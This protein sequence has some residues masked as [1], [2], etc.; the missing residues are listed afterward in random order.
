MSFFNGAFRKYPYQDL[1]EYNLDWI[2]NRLKELDYDMT[3]FVESNVLKYHDPIDWDINT[4]Y[5]AN[6]VVRSGTKVYLSKKPVPVGV[7]IS[8]VNYWFEIGDTGANVN[9]INKRMRM[10]Q[11]APEIALLGDSSIRDITDDTMIT[12]YFNGANVSNYYR[13][14]DGN[15]GW[16]NLNVQIQRISDTPDIIIIQCG[17]NNIP[18]T[19]SADFGGIM[20]APDITDHTVSNNPQTIFEWMKYDINYLKNAF[21][22]AQIYTILRATHPTKPRIYWEY[23]SYFFKAIMREWAVPVIDAQELVNFSTFVTAQNTIF[24]QSDGIHYNQDMYARWLPKLSNII[25]SGSPTDSALTR[26]A[27]FFAPASVLDA[28]YAATSDYNYRALL[29]WVVRH[30]LQPG[31]GSNA[32]TFFGKVAAYDSNNLGHVGVSFL[33]FVD[34][35]AS[36]KIVYTSGA[37]LNSYTLTSSDSVANNGPIVGTRDVASNNT[38]AWYNFQ[39]GDYVV[40]YSA[41]GTLSLPAAVETILAVAQANVIMRIRRSYNDNDQTSYAVH[42][43]FVPSRNASLVKG[44]RRVSDNAESWYEYTGTSISI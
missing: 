42:V 32:G 41:L 15:I 39:V 34:T 30:C 38:R 19:T 11:Q 2:I 5:E 17:S 28:N 44:W 43:E 16:D 37:V 27:Y 29:N 21:P 22:A 4:Q 10:T 20:G 35:N 8:N 18:G 6:T 14:G 36:T 26:P 7:D 40:R 3:A 1:N 33:A 13:S 12:D 9:E 23:Y 31:S 24:T 25:Q